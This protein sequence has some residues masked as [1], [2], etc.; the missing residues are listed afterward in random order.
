MIVAVFKT[1]LLFD[2]LRLRNGI[3]AQQLTAF[4]QFFGFTGTDH[5]NKLFSIKEHPINNGFQVLW[6]CFQARNVG[7]NHLSVHG[8]SDAICT[9]VCNVDLP[10]S[11]LLCDESSFA[12]HSY[13]QTAFGL[14]SATENRPISHLATVKYKVYP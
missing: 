13:C 8:A 4:F 9:L 1:I 5:S 3:L 12:F 10:E 2:L 6:G 7:H 11:C 14:D